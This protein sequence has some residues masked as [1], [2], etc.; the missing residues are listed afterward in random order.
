MIPSRLA[1]RLSRLVANLGFAALAGFLT[2]GC[3]T[4]ARPVAT[5]WQQKLGSELPLLGHRNWIV[6]ADSAY[7]AQSGQGIETIYTGAKQLDAVRDVLAA[8][9]RVKHVQPVVH[10]DSELERVPGTLAQGVEAYRASLGKLLQGR[11]VDRM[12]HGQLIAKLDEAGKTF[13]VL[14]FKTDLTIPYT[15]VFLEL[16]CGYWGPEQERLLRN[17]IGVP[18]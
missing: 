6:I 8:L 13:R 17:A 3:Q 18:P 4:A 7:P 5:T 14:I 12:P 16:D 2:V 9:D 11:R 15:S 10:L 1:R